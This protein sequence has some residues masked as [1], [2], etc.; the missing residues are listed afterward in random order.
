M[1][2]EVML[3]VALSYN[4]LGQINEAMPIF[5][6]IKPYDLS[7]E[8]RGAY[9]ISLAKTHIR[10]GHEK[11]AEDILE[12]SKQGRFLPADKQKI[13]LLLAEI[14]EMEGK[15]D[16]AF[17]LY[18]A[19]VKG[20]RLLPDEDIARAYF[21]MG[22]ISDRD[23]NYEKAR[24]AL[25][26]CIALAEK[27]AHM[28][29]LNQSALIELGNSFYSEGKYARAVRAFQDGFEQGYGPENREYWEMKYRLA[30]SYM[31]IGESSRAE[32]ILSEISDEGDSVLQQK[33]LI[34]LGTIG[35]R[36]QLKRLSIWPYL[37]HEAELGSSR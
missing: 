22:R 24:E 32:P 12:R 4:K 25:N 6:R 34:K 2:P 26:R 5:S 19:V 36:T 15:P 10:A 28:K 23:A 20:Q 14:K 33:A 21:N 16:E 17:A 37:G 9:V 35:L 8:S 18:E 13:A 30:L 29:A 1:D 7:M 27:K 31:G 3:L 11:R